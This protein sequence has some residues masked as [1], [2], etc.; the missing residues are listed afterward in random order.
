MS[1]AYRVNLNV[2]ALVALFTGAFLVFS[3][4]ALSVLRRRPQFALLRVMGVTRRQLLTQV[5]L[6][7]TLLGAAGS[8]L[9]LLLG[10]LLAR[11]ALSL[12]GGDL[13]G[14]YFPGVQPVLQIDVLAA[15]GFFLGG[16]GV[17]MLGSL[18]PAWEA[19]QAKPAPALK[20]GSEEVALSSLRTAWP[21]LTAIVLGAVLTQLPPV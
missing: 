19:A 5:L 14:G 9:G 12:F 18:S 1:R 15:C 21:A 3:T 10:T 20:S 17:A 2:L 16:S 13:G 6:E 11:A 4:Q 7:G 8:L